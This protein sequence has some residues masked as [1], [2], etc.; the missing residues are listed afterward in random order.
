MII[1]YRAPEPKEAQKIAGDFNKDSLDQAARDIVQKLHPLKLEVG[2]LYATISNMFTT[3]EMLQRP[4]TDAALDSRWFLKP[5]DSRFDRTS[6]GFWRLRSVLLA[7]DLVVTFSM[8]KPASSST[9]GN[10]HR[11]AQVIYQIATGRECSDFELTRTIK[12]V[13]RTRD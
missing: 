13:F 1:Y 9:T 10:V 7:I 6:L 2:G 3:L 12:E 4:T 8:R 11:I 5:S